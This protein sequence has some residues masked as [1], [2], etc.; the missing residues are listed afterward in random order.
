M[1]SGFEWFSCRASKGKDV[2]RALVISLAAALLMPQIAKGEETNKS[3]TMYSQKGVPVTV[4]TGKSRQSQKPSELDGTINKLRTSASRLSLPSSMF[5]PWWRTMQ[6]DP[7][8]GW[9][10]RNFD[11][12]A[13]DLERSWPFPVG[14]GAYI[15]RMDTTE[16]D[17]GIRITAEVP[18]ID[19]NNLDVTVTEDAITIK[20]DKKDEV[21]QESKKG[22][23]LH[24]IE[25]SYGSFERTISLPCKVDSD[26][27]QA[28][29][30][31]G[32]L[33]ISVPKLPGQ[34]NEGKKLTI[35]RE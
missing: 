5:E 16:S 27:A 15:P 32:I 13:S 6:R 2:K 29:L 28:T 23:A 12:M 9:I 1:K 3:E 8:A 30:K 18:G 19:E 26:K 11:I 7:D 21:A 10:L 4:H 34:Q 24:T 33:T 22:G 31:N 20:G 25:R 14:T 17:S 35:R